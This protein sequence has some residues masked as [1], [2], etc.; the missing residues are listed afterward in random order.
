MAK[1]PS[2]RGFADGQML[3]AMPQMLDQRFRETVIYMCSHNDGGAIGLVINKA[4]E[5][6]PLH[7][8]LRQA[9]IEID[10]KPDAP[11]KHLPGAVYFGGPVEPNRG[12]VLHSGEYQRD[13]TSMVGDGIAMTS[14]TEILRD[15][16]DGAGP[17]QFL[18]ALGYAGWAPGQLDHEIRDNGWLLVPADPELVFGPDNAGKWQ[19]AVAK[20]G[21]APN[22]LYHDPGHA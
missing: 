20:L 8:V 18:L 6:V 5:G 21:I 15:I 16:A 7:E 3:V 12:F 4:I 1:T 19:R 14:T 22:A 17:R 13:G 11:A 9:G 10:D 2:K